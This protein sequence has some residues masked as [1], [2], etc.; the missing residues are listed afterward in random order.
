MPA[1]N[2]SWR[3]AMWWLIAIRDA[4]SALA[5]DCRELKST[6]ARSSCAAFSRASL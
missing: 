6:Q 1:G 3:V 4:R 5:R 2:D